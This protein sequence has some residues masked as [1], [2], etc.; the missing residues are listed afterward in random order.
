MQKMKTGKPFYGWYVLG[1]A[2][3]VT[4]VVGGAYMNTFGVFLPVLTEKFGWS[5]AEVSL[6]LSMGMIAFGLPSLL[7]SLV[8]TRFGARFCIILG[9]LLAAMGMAAMYFVQEI[10]HLYLLYIFIGGI[11]GVGGYLACTTIANNWFVKRRALV[12][13]MLTASAGIGGLIYPPITTALVNAIGWRETWLG[14]AGLVIVSGTGPGGGVVREKTG[15]K[16]E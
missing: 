15:G 8:I 12:M 16:G 5:R 4:L 10:W 13:G 11:S 9:N 6:A 1:G 3:L 7:Y 14:L 2:M